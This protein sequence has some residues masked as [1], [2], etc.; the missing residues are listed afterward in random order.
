M[1]RVTIE[2][3]GRAAEG[4]DR[5]LRLELPEGATAAD[6]AGRLTERYPELDWLRRVTKPAVNLE[7]TSWDHVLREGDE[8]A[9][10][11]PVSGG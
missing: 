2:L 8:L 5:T 10:I 4:R 1:I 7:Y 6:A 9:F 11:P 3:V